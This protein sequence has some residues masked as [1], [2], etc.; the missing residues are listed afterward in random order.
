MHSGKFVT[1]LCGKDIRSSQSNTKN[2]SPAREKSLPKTL[3]AV[4]FNAETHRIVP[5]SLLETLHD[6]QS[7]AFCYALSSVLWDL[8]SAQLS[9]PGLRDAP[10]TLQTVETN[11][12]ARNL[13]LASQF[14]FAFCSGSNRT[15][16]LVSNHSKEGRWN[17]VSSLSN[18]SPSTTQTSKTEV[19][20][21]R[22]CNTNK[23]KLA[24]QFFLAFHI[25]G[26]NSAPD[27]NKILIGS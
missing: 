26:K 6:V 19:I 3:S 5:C 16:V 27:P 4:A 2:K 23:I 18:T 11:F 10:G 25:P 13:A 21:T 20:K 22:S 17:P 24:R 9:L 7:W 1:T 15:S 14:Y 8:K 12:P